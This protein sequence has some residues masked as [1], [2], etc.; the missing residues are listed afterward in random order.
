MWASSVFTAD[1]TTLELDRA[2][3]SE[4]IEAARAVGD[5]RVQEAATGRIDPESWTH[6]SSDQRERWF[7]RGYETG[8]PTSCD[9]FSVENL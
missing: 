2:D 1:N 3:I 8:D 5:D 9:T 7:I 4:G 6:G